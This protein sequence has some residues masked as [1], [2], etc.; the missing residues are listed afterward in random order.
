MSNI[1]HLDI[2]SSVFYIH[3]FSGGFAYVT[4]DPSKQNDK[5]A[6]EKADGHEKNFNFLFLLHKGIYY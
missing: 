5:T 1:A 6:L 4:Q 2:L 3:L